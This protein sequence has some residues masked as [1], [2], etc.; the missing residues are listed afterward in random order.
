MLSSPRKQHKKH[1]DKVVFHVCHC[2]NLSLQG[3]LK[4]LTRPVTLQ[5]PRNVSFKQLVV[6]WQCTA[7]GCFQCAILDLVGFCPVLL[8]Q[9]Q[10]FQDCTP[11]PEHCGG[12]GGCEGATS[13]L[14][15]EYAS[16]PLIWFDLGWRRKNYTDKKV[17][18]HGKK[19]VNTRWRWGNVRVVVMKLACIRG[20]D[21]M[22]PSTTVGTSIETW[23]RIIQVT[24]KSPNDV[25][26][27][28]LYMACV[29]GDSK[30]RIQWSPILVFKAFRP[31]HVELLWVYLHS[32]KISQPDLRGWALQSIIKEVPGTDKAE[33]IFLW[34]LVS[35]WN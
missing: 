4:K 13:E 28:C 1:S 19:W 14:A 33:K 26:T 12:D 9:L 11:N 32:V 16:K 21:C 15:F 17:E 7:V 30:K 6:T 2:W 25:D 18:D 29:Q 34:E 27:S 3:V 10:Q 35:P 24:Q 5:V 22:I 23:W 31:S 8:N 20:M